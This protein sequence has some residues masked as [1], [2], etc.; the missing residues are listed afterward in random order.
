MKNMY[1]FLMV[2]ILAGLVFSGCEI[3]NDRTV[4]GKG[5]V[6]SMDVVTDDFTGVNVIGTCDVNIEIGESQ[7]VTYY[8]QQNILDVMTYH[9]VNGILQISFDPDVSINTD[10][11]IRAEIT[12]PEVSYIS[13]T[14]AG[15]FDLD[16][17][18]QSRL[19]IHIIGAG[20]VDAY[21][22]N[23]DACNINIEGSGN[24]KVWVNNTLDVD[25]S[26]FGVVY[27]KGDPQVSSNIYGTGSINNDN[28]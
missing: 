4:V 3:R 7:S 17:S 11:E 28:K 14:G 18:K 24:C 15:N 25:I 2:L 27:F 22:M 20:N 8:A 23:V 19:D 12:I 26:G 13:V 9:V 6:V 16:G 10:K 21:G 1:K 5:D